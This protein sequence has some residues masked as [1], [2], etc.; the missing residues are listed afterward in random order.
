MAQ[1]A[2]QRAEIAPLDHEQALELAKALPEEKAEALT[3]YL[4]ALRTRNIAVLGEDEAFKL[5]DSQGEIRAFRSVIKLSGKGRHPGPA[6]PRRPERHLGPRIRGMGGSRR[7]HR[8]ERAPRPG[9]RKDGPEPPR[10]TRPR[11]Q[12]HH[13]D[14][15]PG[16]RFSVLEQGDPAGV[17]PHHDLRRS[18]LP[19]HRPAL[20]RPRNTPRPSSY[21]RRT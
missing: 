2:Q 19:A 5:T 9:R 20:Q 13:R 21:C 17:R 11:Q 4:E 1:Q 3:G 10:P 6:G 8:H 18:P 7:R 15:L 12:P 16:D 14:L